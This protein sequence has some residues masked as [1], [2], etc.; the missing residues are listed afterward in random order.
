MV[1]LTWSDKEEMAIFRLKSRFESL[2]WLWE[3]KK[4]EEEG[5]EAMSCPKCGGVVG[6]VSDICLECGFDT[7]SED[8]RISKIY[9]VFVFS[10]CVILSMWF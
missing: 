5:K 7:D 2:M 6:P 4:K 8:L 10:I 9:A 1:E 3:N